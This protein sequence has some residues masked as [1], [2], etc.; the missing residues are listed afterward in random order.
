MRKAII[1]IVSIL[2]LG[3]GAGP[4]FSK[5]DLL[6]QHKE[7]LE[8]V[9]PI[10]TKTEREVFLKLRTPE[11]RN[12]FIQFFWKQRDPRPDTA[13]NEFYKEYMERV[14]FADQTFHDSG[15]KGSLTERGYYY[16]LLGPPLERTTYTT[17]SQ[18][19]PL[20]LWFY[21]GDQQYGLPPYFYLIFYQPE[22]IGEYRLYSPGVEGPEKL[23]IPSLYGSDLNRSAAYQAIK[24]INA[25]LARA[26]LSYLPGDQ[27]YGLSSFSSDTVIASVR[28]YPGKKFSDAYARSYLN[29][30]DSV[31]TEYSDNYIQSS[32]KV[33]VF[34]SSG[35]FF[36]HWSCEPEKVS[37]A[38]YGETYSA[39]FD[40]ILKME[41]LQGNPIL[42]KE[43]E[44]PLK[45]NAEQ[46]KKH[47][48]QH[49]AFQ[50]ILPAIAGKYKFFVLIK[51]K[52]AKDFSSFDTEVSVPEEA[53]SPLVSNLLLYHARERI[54]DAQKNNL[55]AFSFAANQYLFNTRNEFAPQGELG[56]Y[57]QAY[58]FQNKLENSVASVLFE[59]NSLDSK[60]VVVSQKKSLA[61]VLSFD[62]EGMDIGPFSLSTLKP[63][64]FEVEVSLLDAS[65]RKL[66]SGKEGFVL[67]AQPYLVLP[68]IYS[69]LHNPFPN[70]EDLYLLSSQYFIVQKY[71]KAR[72]LLEQALRLKDEPR[73]RLLLAKSLFGLKQYQ[74]SITLV[75]PVY[76]ATH[77]REAAKVIALNYAGLKDWSSA[78]IYL[79][80]LLEEATEVGVLN[81]AAEC[82]LNLSQPE[83]ALPLIQK[84]LELNPSQPA[85]KELDEKAKKAMLK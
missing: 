35:Q 13:E 75:V 36:I 17:V 5:E 61:E 11:E 21:K 58:N 67:L 80:K 52:T 15:K 37:F 40:L 51:N 9:A 64:Y 49:F 8:L 10:I 38:Q 41:D 65:G 71:E 79:S 22:G 66:L 14:R 54:L 46:Y 57:L 53:G 76:Q 33:K 70:S 39:N 16:L 84:S 24:K 32:S 50:D 78:L 6:P 55:K 68:W 19:W 4:F 59:I 72:N 25:E 7:W 83:K 30:K 47:E 29:Y 27:P 45:L 1:S 60:S 28:S 85:V 69:R 20:E 3:I 77:N 56:C 44:I 74:D 31:E 43:E 12:K 18:I 81:L 73:I 82:Y 2:I 34:K 26:S 42:E 62:K 63:G 48:R 23:V